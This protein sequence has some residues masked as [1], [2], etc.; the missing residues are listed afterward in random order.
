L[1]H[2]RFLKYNNRLPVQQ[3]GYEMLDRNHENNL[4]KQ[5]VYAEL[6]KEIDPFRDREYFRPL[7]RAYTGDNTFWSVPSPEPDLEDDFWEFLKNSLDSE[8]VKS[9]AQTLAASVRQW[10]EEGNR[11]LFAAILRAGVP[12]ADWLSQMIPGSIAV[13]LS[14]FVGLGIDRAALRMIKEHFPER[15]ILFVDGWT[16][17]GGV[18]RAIRDLGVGPLAVLNDPWGWADFS[19]M[20]ADIFCPTACFTGLGT[21]GFSRTFFEK[22]KRLFAAYRF[23]RKYCR[24]ALVETWQKL[25]PR[26]EG[27]PALWERK[28]AFFRETP[29]RI[30][31]NEV[32]RAL[33]NAAPAQLFFADDAAYVKEHYPLLLMLAEQRKVKVLYERKELKEL[34]TRAACTL[35]TV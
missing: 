2:Y 1:T 8:T 34:K 30:H 26:N 14:L 18:A 29:L 31:T 3:Q 35:H 28:E 5:T 11:L 13:S 20:D 24:K 27:H 23:P 22:E 9:A 16:G 7:N 21:L 25:C 17:R 4:W 6:K 19:G 10:E 32:C 15:K 33:I 12:V